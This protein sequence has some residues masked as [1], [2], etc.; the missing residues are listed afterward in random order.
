[1]FRT[2]EEPPISLTGNAR[3]AEVLKLRAEQK[4]VKKAAEEAVEPLDAE[5]KYAIGNHSMA[6]CG[7]TTISF[8]LTRRKGYSV[9]PTEYRALRIS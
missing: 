4:A 9:A 8:K 5:L 3:I 7:S 6:Y 1:V 2:D